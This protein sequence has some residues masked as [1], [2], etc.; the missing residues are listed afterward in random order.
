MSAIDAQEKFYN[1]QMDDPQRIV[2]WSYGKSG[3]I[4]FLRTLFGPACDDDKT[5]G[6]NYYWQVIEM[7]DRLDNYDP[8]VM[9][10]DPLFC[11]FC[12]KR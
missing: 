11:E 3:L 10:E 12:K 5:E 1:E 6:L 8:D 4:N 9:C 2:K 7:L